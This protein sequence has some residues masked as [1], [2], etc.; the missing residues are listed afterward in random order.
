M[1]KTE[2]EIKT[3]DQP[4]RDNRWQPTVLRIRGTRQN[5]AGHATDDQYATKA[6]ITSDRQIIYF[7]TVILSSLQIDWEIQLNLSLGV[8][9]EL[10]RCMC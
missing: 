5:I 10:W 8:V 2:K 9:Y 7:H 4:E 3:I 6:I 1:Y